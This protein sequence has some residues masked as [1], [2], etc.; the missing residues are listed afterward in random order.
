MT[1]PA[2]AQTDGKATANDKTDDSKKSAAATLES[3][4]GPITAL[5]VTVLAGA[6]MW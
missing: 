2:P 6:F 3:F 5:L 4:R 1:G